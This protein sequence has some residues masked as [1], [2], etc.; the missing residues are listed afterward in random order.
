MKKGSNLYK[1]MLLKQEEYKD[2]YM[3]LNNA[4]H[5]FFKSFCNDENSRIRVD[6]YNFVIVRCADDVPP[7]LLRK[8]QNDFD[9]KLLWESKEH[10]KDYRNVEGN[11]TNAIVYEYG[12]AP[13][14]LL[15]AD[16]GKRNISDD[17]EEDE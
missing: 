6:E 5:E 11:E 9:V 7:E 4:V 8:F 3:K 13:H 10:I 2:S 17:G 15:T 12:F 16:A 14:S 1:K